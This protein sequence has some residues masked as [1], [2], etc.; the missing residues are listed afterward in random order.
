MLPGNIQKWV[1][2][3][4]LLYVILV[5]KNIVEKQ[6]VGKTSSKIYHFPLLRRKCGQ[7]HRS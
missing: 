1:P 6:T 5:L 2:A 3:E 7:R 4:K